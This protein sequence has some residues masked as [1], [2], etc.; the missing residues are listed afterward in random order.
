MTWVKTDPTAEGLPHVLASHSLNADALSAHRALYEK[1]MFG[2]SDLTRAE[3]EAI[4]VC[5][6]AANDCHY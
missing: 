5:V 1:L 3:R 2:P 6:S 4:A